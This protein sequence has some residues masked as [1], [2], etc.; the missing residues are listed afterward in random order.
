[1]NCG[2]MSE[3]HCVLVD[4]TEHDCYLP[5]WVDAKDAPVKVPAPDEQTHKKPTLVALI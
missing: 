1:M 5:C 2:L 4:S 3:N